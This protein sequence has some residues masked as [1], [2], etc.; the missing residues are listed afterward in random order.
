MK[1]FIK[2]TLKKTGQSLA[3]D[4]KFKGQLWRKLEGELAAKTPVSSAWY[5]HFSVRYAVVVVAAVGIVTCGATG[6]YAYTSP[7][8]TVGTPLYPL[9]KTME[10]VE[11]KLKTTP[12]ARAAFL[13]KTIDRREA[14]KKVLQQQ[15]REI[16]KINR[17]ISA[18][19]KQLEKTT[20]ELQETTLEDTTLSEKIRVR[21]EQRENRLKKKAEELENKRRNRG[22]QGI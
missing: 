20:A 16:T 3:P 15:H 1:F 2:H 14:E 11:G 6:A 17:E 21:L 7:A 5:R 4:E 10:K 18:T 8:V 22:K 12:A 9:K 19:E 13:L